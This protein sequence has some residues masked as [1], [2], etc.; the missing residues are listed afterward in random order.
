M[1]C[2]LD[3]IFLSDILKY[4]HNIIVVVLPDKRFLEVIEFVNGSHLDLPKKHLTGE[5]TPRIL[6][7]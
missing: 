5:I 2:N 1:L 7:H 6:I 3:R 4:S